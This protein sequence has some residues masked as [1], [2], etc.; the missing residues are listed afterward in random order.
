[1]TDRYRFEI[2]RD[3]KR[4]VQIAEG[5]FPNIKANPIEQIVPLSPPVVA[6]YFRFTG[7]HAVEK[8][9]VSAAEVGVIA[10]P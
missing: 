4:W 1:M 3:G 9:H 6:R 8:N 2:S 5:E 10:A 7:L